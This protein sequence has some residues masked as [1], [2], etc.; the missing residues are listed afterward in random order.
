MNP[1]VS[2]ILPTYNGAAFITGAIE[3]V[4][5]QTYTNWELLII[6]DGSTDQTKTIVEDFTKKDPRIFFIE[7]RE[8]SGIQK[9]LNRGIVLAKGTYVARLDDDDRWTDPE[10]LSLQI[11]FFETYPD[12]VLLG[13][14][15]TVVS[16]EGETISKSSM[17]LTDSAIR[18]RMLSKNCFLHATVIIRKKALEKIG[19]YSEDKKFFHVEDY[20]LW[21][22]L[23]REGAMANLAVYSTTLTAHEKSLTSRNRVLQAANMIKA[24]QVYRNYYPNFYT[25]IVVSI[26]R[27][28]GFAVIKSIPLPKR[29]FYAIQRVYK[30]V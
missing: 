19:G 23:G 3:G 24:V 7:N 14:N 11:A 30:A 12:H 29:W 28:L 9:T 10:K 6:S 13:T 2:I 26:L 25:G 15:A 27:Y 21:L 4:L 18:S 5:A 20:E 16:L 1:L 22:R 8:N 17:P